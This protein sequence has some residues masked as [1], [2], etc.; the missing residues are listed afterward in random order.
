VEEDLMGA[1][2]E[3]FVNQIESK[4]Q[5]AITTLEKLNEADWAKVTEAEKWSVGVTAHH[6]AGAFEAVSDAVKK[7][8]GGEPLG[9]TMDMIHEMNARHAREYAN[10]T[11]AETVD[12]LKKGARV[13]AA[14]VRGLTDDQLMKSGTFGPGGP[15]LTAEQLIH[16][17]LIGHANEHLASIRKTVGK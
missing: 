6:L 10:C 2:S 4:V 11:R 15:T 12:M 17:G 8:V 16:M 5:E 7:I 14:A 9:F 1:K 13:A 3:V